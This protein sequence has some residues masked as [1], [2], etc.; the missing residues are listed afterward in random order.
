[1]GEI[2]KVFFRIFLKM[3]VTIIFCKP[4]QQDCHGT[5][6]DSPC[7][8]FCNCS[9]GWLAAPAHRTGGCNGVCVSNPAGFEAASNPKIKSGLLDQSKLKC[10]IL[11]FSKLKQ[12]L[13]SRC[14]TNFEFPYCEHL[15][16]IVQY[17][18]LRGDQKLVGP[19]GSKPVG[20]GV[21]R[22]IATSVGTSASLFG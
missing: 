10:F 18:P 12:R 4:L 8:H 13:R 2:K 1:M 17:M 5:G 9:A 6:F 3:A 7:L 11:F 14:F 21:V 16:K 15:V 19:A 20:R 22:T